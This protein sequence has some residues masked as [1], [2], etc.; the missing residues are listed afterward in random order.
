[1]PPIISDPFFYAVAVPAVILMGLAKGGFSGLGLLSMS[2][3]SLAV[4]PVKAAAIMLPILVVQDWVSVWAYRSSFDKRL[5][6]IMLPGSILGI[7]FGY[8][9]AAQVS[10]AVVRLI[11]GVISVVFVGIFW[12]RR[13]LPTA[14]SGDQGK[15]PAGVFWGAVAGY[16]SFVAHAGGPPFQVYV[17]P[18]RLSPG[19][20][21][22]T[23]TMFFTVTNA[24]KLI[25]YFALGQFSSENLSSSAALFPVAIGATL[26]GVWLIRR[27]DAPRFYSIVYGLTLFVGLKL[28]YDAL[29][30][31]F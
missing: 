8:L 30:D 10:E 29:R 21:A 9:I 11:V 18:L 31:L 15:A 2:M 7:T 24:L 14:D 1:M 6:A 16:T 20:Y 28:V 12:R 26:A 25:P 4:S 17:M 5:L 3:L 19:L 13:S 27:I 22:G 23:N